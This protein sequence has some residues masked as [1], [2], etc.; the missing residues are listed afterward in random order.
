MPGELAIAAP[1]RPREGGRGLAANMVARAW[2]T[3][4]FRIGALVFALL[5]L[6]SIFGPDL[7]GLSATR[8]DV[9]HRFMPPMP[10]AGS[11]WP[12]LLGTDQ[13]GRD[14]FVR[15]G[16]GRTARLNRS[17]TTSRPAMRYMVGA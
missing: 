2:M 4:E 13:L 16:I 3:T 12:H 14:L 10:L 15:S 8:F 6:L 9:A 11:M 17:P 5:M 7:V 1:A